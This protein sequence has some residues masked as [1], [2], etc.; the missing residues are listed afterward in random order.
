M[1]TQ[2]IIRRKEFSTGN[3]FVVCVEVS[4]EEFEMSDGKIL[5]W[6]FKQ[7]KKQLFNHLKEKNFD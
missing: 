5:D 4:N 3:E 1:A 6:K 2:I 7:L